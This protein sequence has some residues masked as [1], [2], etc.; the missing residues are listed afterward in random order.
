VV[1]ATFF[2]DVTTSSGSRRVDHAG[3]VFD[4]QGRLLGA[5]C[6]MGRETL[7]AGLNSSRIG[8]GHARLVGAGG[9]V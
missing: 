4:G 1:V 9:A 5:G 8:A 6:G 2:F 7:G 3:G